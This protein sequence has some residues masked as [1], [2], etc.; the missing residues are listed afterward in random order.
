MGPA[1]AGYAAQ[2]ERLADAHGLDDRLEICPPVA[3]ADV[4]AALADAHVGVSLFQP[5]CL[6]H[7]LTLPN[8]VFEYLAAGVPMLVSDLPVMRDFVAEHGLGDAAPPS[9]P[10]AIAQRIHELLE[11]DRNAR[12]R[13]NVRGVARRLTWQR[14]QRAL[15]DAYRQA[16]Q[17]SG[18]AVVLDP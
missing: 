14:E 8:K 9:R 18:S 2:L 17:R 10:D 15:V 4:P 6:S 5:V 13:E 3:P 12:L 7:E 16:L 1:R 11:P